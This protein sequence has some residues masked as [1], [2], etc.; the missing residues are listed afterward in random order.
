[1]H[2]RCHHKPLLPRQ[3]HRRIDPNL[4]SPA[5]GAVAVLTRVWAVASTD[6]V[7]VRRSWRRKDVSDRMVVFVDWMIRFGDGCIEAMVQP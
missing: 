3:Y 5:D 4:K 7:K 6:V 1:M 2:P